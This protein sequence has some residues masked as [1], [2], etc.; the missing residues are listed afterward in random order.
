MSFFNK[1]NDVLIV[2]IFKQICQRRDIN[3]EVFASDTLFPLI[4]ANLGHSNRICIMESG[5]SQDR[6][7]S[8]VNIKI[9]RF[10]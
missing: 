2:D 6:K 9:R 7:F 10:V 1:I 5:R 8:K 3:I 4:H